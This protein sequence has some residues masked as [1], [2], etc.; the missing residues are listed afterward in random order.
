MDGLN[1]PPHRQSSLVVTVPV[2]SFH[3]TDHLGSITVSTDEKGNITELSDYYPYGSI[4]GEEKSGSSSKE[5]R[6]YIGQEF[7]A[8][9]QLSYLNARYYYSARG[10]FISQD[11]VFWEVGMTQDGKSVLANPQALNS[12][13]YAGNNPI[14]KSDPTGRCIEDLC[15]GEAIAISS[16]AAIYAPQITA[17]AQSLLSPIG[18]V[19]IS[20]AVDDVKGGNYKMAA[21]GF[22]TAGEFSGASKVVSGLERQT[23]L[24]SKIGEGSN[25]RVVNLIK[26]TFKSTDGL[27]GGTVGAI[28]NEMMTGQATNGVWHAFEKTQN[29]LSRTGN[30]LRDYSAG[31][32]SLKPI[33]IGIVKGIQKGVERAVANFNKSQIGK[34]LKP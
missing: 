25:S 6:K 12:Y 13:S 10:Q 4:R 31:K 17:F 8:T 28:K 22:V 1:P 2:I 32:I 24:I 16:L 7:D 26:A 3:L 34:I 21:V 29:T 30:I 14:T 19:G 5:Q 11:P 18:Q 23:Q 20:Q 27:L 9:T 33:E 15:I